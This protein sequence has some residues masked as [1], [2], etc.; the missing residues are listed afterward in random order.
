MSESFAEAQ[1]ELTGR[2]E[3]FL[4]RQEELDRLDR[5]AQRGSLG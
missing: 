5:R 4:K 3:D 1:D 2:F